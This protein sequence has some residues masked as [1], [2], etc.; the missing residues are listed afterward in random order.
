MADSLRGCGDALMPTIITVLGVCGI[1]VVWL[2]TVLPRFRTMRTVMMSYPISWVIS[3]AAFVA[4][5]EYFV[6]KH[7]IAAGKN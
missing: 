3:S 6:R 4:Y 2:Y 7:H 1:R 5:Y